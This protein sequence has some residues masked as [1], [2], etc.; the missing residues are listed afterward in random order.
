MELLDRATAA[1]MLD[2]L[3]AESVRYGRTLSVVRLR[4]PADDVPEAAARLRFAVRDADLLVRWSEE[5]VLALLPETDSDGAEAAADRLRDA[6]RDMP[7]HAGIAQWSGETGDVL[8]RRAGW[9]AVR[10]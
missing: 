2:R 6:V 1:Y 9:A 8:L 5:D 7:V 4:M 3:I 10:P